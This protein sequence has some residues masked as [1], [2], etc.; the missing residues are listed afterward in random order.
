MTRMTKSTQWRWWQIWIACCAILL[1]ALAPSMSQAIAAVR[2]QAVAWEICRVDGAPGSGASVALS[3]APARLGA[4]DGA[5]AGDDKMKPG[6]HCAYCLT[7]AGSFGLPPAMAATVG[8]FG[9][10]PQ[11]PFLFYRSPR[12]LTAW[13][14]ARPRGPPALA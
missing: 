1:N 8:V 4:P 6:E 10:H 11:H 12:P 9:S 3:A 7:H 5:P 2:G 14:A 13:S